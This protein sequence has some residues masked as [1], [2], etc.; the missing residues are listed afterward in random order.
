MF[1]EGWVLLFLV[2][3]LIIT[4]MLSALQSYCVLILLIC[5]ALKSCKFLLGRS[6]L[7]SLEIDR[8]TE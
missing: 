5:V 3:I 2:I 4:H 1:L 7:F 8:T 6:P